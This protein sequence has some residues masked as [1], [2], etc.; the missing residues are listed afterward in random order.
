MPT[1]LQCKQLK[2]N[3]KLI[4]TTVRND[5]LR[6]HLRNVEAANKVVNPSK[7][8]I[9]YDKF[10]SCRSLQ[11]LSH[12]QVVNEITASAPFTRS[13]SKHA[14]LI[15]TMKLLMMMRVINKLL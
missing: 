4:K 2:V 7:E 10:T 8:V 12:E 15:M 3:V 6:Q 14:I 5:L 13:R 9:I 11:R 1:S